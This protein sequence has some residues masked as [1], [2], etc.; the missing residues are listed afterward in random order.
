MLSSQAPVGRAS[1][2]AAIA[3]LTFSLLAPGA[4]A[5]PRVIGPTPPVISGSP[6]TTAVEG[7]SYRFQPTA[8]DADGDPLKFSIRGK[9]GW[10][11]FD[12]RTGALY[13]T[14]AA[15]TAGMYANIII[16]VTD[17]RNAT[18]LPAFSITV[19][20]AATKAANSAPTISGTPATSVPAGQ[21]YSFKPSAS[22]V[23]GDLLTFN[24]QGKPAWASF[25]YATGTLSGTPAS[26]DVGTFSGIVISVTDGTAS[27]S[28]PSFSITV[29]AVNNAPKISGTPAPSVLGGQAYSFT[30]TA[31]D[32]DGDPLTFSIQGKPAWATFSS[33]TGALT[34]TPT[35]AQAGTYSNIV[36]SVSDGK[37][38][39]SLPAFSITVTAVNS[40]PTISGTPATSVLS[41]QSYSFKPLATD[42]DNDPLTFSIQGKPAW[43]TFSSSTGA[44]TGTPTSTQAGTYSS[45]VISVS[46]GKATASLPAFS[47]TVTAVNSAPKISGTPVT[48][49]EVDRPYS[50]KPTAYDADSDPLTFSIQGKPAWAAF[51][52]T[53]GTL[54]GTPTSANVGTTGNI[55]ISVSDGKAT[56]SLPAFTITVAAAPVASV[57][58][59]WSKPTTNAD[60]TPL[61]DLA[62]YKVFYGNAS[63]QYSYNLSVS[64]A[65]VT[66]TVLEGLASGTTWYF[67][68]K[69]VT[70]G[71][72]ESDYSGEVTRAL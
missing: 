44:L 68:V 4:H 59:T 34:G 47:I 1:F 61:T 20:V 22:D 43:A 36:I 16:S 46:D 54:Y 65:S 19:S 51:D 39:A 25:S 2:V 60:G 9:P 52:T 18:S 66:S 48:S 42:A 63:R 32:A 58:L 28:L 50:F 10:A 35:S 33:S 24:I 30:P 62:G 8:S 27:T 57:T 13:G 21:L 6:A 31:S 17:G 38:T 67:S 41:G 29:T 37:A 15:G 56:S 69:S 72:V 3:S 55:V 64:G 53:S 49:A 12:R 5:A 40:A 7:E 71:G 11:A 14:P 45:I 23:D 70:S 26:T